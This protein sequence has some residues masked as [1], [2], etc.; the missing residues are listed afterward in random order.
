[1][2]KILVKKDLNVVCS[3]NNSGRLKYDGVLC[4]GK[5]Y[6][7]T[8][9]HGN[10]DGGLSLEINNSRSNIYPDTIREAINSK[11][12]LKIK[13]N[14]KV[15]ILPC[16]PKKV[17]S[18]YGK[19]LKKNHI[20]LFCNNWGGD[21]EFAFYDGDFVHIDD[22]YKPKTKVTLLV[23]KRNEIQREYDNGNLI[24][25]VLRIS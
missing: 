2:A 23:G 4:D 10:R 12:G 21:T 11:L 5:S 25:E 9:C 6:Y 14:D 20:S 3:S 22:T 17:R 19:Q 15:F 24:E 16:H 1:M 13:D 18:E 7:I 8:C